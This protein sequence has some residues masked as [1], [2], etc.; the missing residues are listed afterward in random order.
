MEV[1]RTHGTSPLSFTTRDG[2]PLWSW[3]P[4]YDNSPKEPNETHDTFIKV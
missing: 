3:S 2:D 4:D 1:G